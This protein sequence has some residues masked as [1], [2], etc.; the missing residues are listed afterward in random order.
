MSGID[1]IMAILFIVLWIIFGFLT[2]LIVTGIISIIVY[3]VF[4]LGG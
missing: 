2:S 3:G 1:I 4:N